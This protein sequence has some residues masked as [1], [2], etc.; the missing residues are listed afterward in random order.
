MVAFRLPLA[1]SP[2]QVAAY[3]G[4]VCLFSIS[5]LVFL[6]SSLS[7]VVTDLIG[8]R[9]GVGDAVGTLGFADELLALVAC[10]LWGLLSDRIGVRYVVVAGYTLVALAL[11]VFVQATDVY[12]HLLPARLLFSLG[13]AAS[14]T[15]V[16]AILPS[17]S[18]P[19]PAA[20][21]RPAS[22]AP[23]PASPAPTLAC[24][25][26]VPASP[27]A[28]AADDAPAPRMAATSRASTSQIAG[29]VG[30]FTGMG[31]LVALGL[32][33]PLPARLA[34]VAGS[35]RQ[36]LVYSFYIVAAVA[37][38]VAAFCFVGL[39]R[40]PGEETKGFHRLFAAG[41]R[42]HH[43]L[44]AGQHP[45]PTSAVPY[46]RLAAAAVKLGFT[47]LDIGLGYVG[48]FVARASSV[49]ISLFI[50]LYVNA[51][52]ISAGL[53]TGEPGADLK[54]QCER[55]YK[56][57][58]MLTG[59]AELCALLFAPVFGYLDGRFHRL[60]GP[61]VVAAALGIVGYVLLA[62]LTPDPAAPE[63]G[64]A[65]FVVMGLLGVSQIGAIVCS[66]SVLG[67]GIQGSGGEA[68]NLL[69]AH[70]SGGITHNAQDA[71]GTAY[72]GRG[73]DNRDGT[74]ETAPLLDSAPPADAA[75]VEVPTRNHLKGSVAG[76]YSLGGGAGILLLTKA[77]G[78]LFD[79]AGHGAPFYMMAGANALLLVVAAA[80]AVVSGAHRKEIGLS[81]D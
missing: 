69:D 32:F 18:R 65:L 68:D 60:N 28:R 50:P 53:C 67:R 74:G 58:A 5:F 54:S 51:H 22:P 3:L 24:P 71:R 12:R 30:M 57:A 42:S 29:L 55:A 8:Q 59:V 7:F 56:T 13:A 16:T 25:A 73:T 61:I 72:D 11:V 4:G 64:P 21:P 19:R 37:L 35:R 39:R 77:G 33:L 27:Q 31:A 41:R 76:V 15:M 6:N 40:L 80:C 38:A 78:A 70:D 81:R 10:P 17:M 34:D 48:G 79:Q 26:R 45:R 44:L 9:K 36:A 62:R 43:V 2:L 14:T 20:P 1:A 49:A 75:V 52:F 46:F 23:V 63:G 66:L 47:D